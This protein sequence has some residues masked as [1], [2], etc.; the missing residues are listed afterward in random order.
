MLN[1]LINL[2]FSTLE[3]WSFEFSYCLP[4]YYPWIK[5][6]RTRLRLQSSERIIMNIF[7][8]SNS[9]QPFFD[10][11]QHVTHK[12][13]IRLCYRERFVSSRSSTQKHFQ[14]LYSV[15]LEV[16]LP[17]LFVKNTNT[18]FL[19]L[20]SYLIAPSTH[21]TIFISRNF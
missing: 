11:V 18:G 9:L 3:L 12:W 19:P 4:L 1:N 2:D 20:L 8:E 5:G 13:H 17:T 21:T 7:N 16:H 14:A 10:E 6:L 15:N